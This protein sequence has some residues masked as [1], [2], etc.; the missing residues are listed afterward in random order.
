MADS[1]EELTARVNVD[2]PDPRIACALL[3]DTSNSMA[4]DKISLLNDGFDLFCKEIKEDDLAKKRTEVMVVTFGGV[5]RVEIPFTEGRDLQSRQFIADGGTPL[6]A[7]ID[8]ALDE[9]TAQK[10]AYKQN[11]L[12]Y[13]R[14]WL[15]VMTDG[16]PTDGP[17][18]ESAAARVCSIE[19]SKGVSCFP[20]G[21]GE[22]AGMDQ[23]AKL[24]SQRTPLKLTGL[25]FKEFFLWLS[26]SMSVVSGTAAHSPSD[27]GAD[28]DAQHPLPPP[29]GWAK[30]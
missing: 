16:A 7:A 24:S 12:E 17:V 9:L 29:T 11:G 20:I 18:F 3:L 21:I 19:A 5:A 1:E 13:Y 22:D 10:E 26:A 27:D 25:S 2:N 30:W 14:P 4:G 15:F 23:L 6:G 28:K 8:L